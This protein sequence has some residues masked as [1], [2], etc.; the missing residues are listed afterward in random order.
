[1]LVL[2]R[3]S[4]EALVIDGQIEVIVLGVEGDKVKI[5]IIAPREVQILRKELYQ[6]IQA[7]T[8]IQEK[9]AEGVEPDTFNSLRTL[10]LSAY[11]V[12]E[13]LVEQKNQ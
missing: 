12:E 9:L 8:A 5:G 2:T 3:K 6:G 4:G 10:L 1:V 11:G 13:E 7:Q